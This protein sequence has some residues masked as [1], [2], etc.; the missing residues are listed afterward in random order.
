MT[1]H[2][3]DQNRVNPVQCKQ[4]GKMVVRV[5]II[6]VLTV[7]IL[8]DISKAAPK[9]KTDVDIKASEVDTIRAKPQEPEVILLIPKANQ[10]K[11]DK[12]KK[13]LAPK[14]QKETEKQ[15]FGKR[16]TYKTGSLFGSW[17]KGPHKSHSFSYH[18]IPVAQVLSD[19][20]KL[21]RLNIV[22]ADNVK[23]EVTFSA[24]NI[25]WIQALRAIVDATGLTAKCEGSIV[26]IEPK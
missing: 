3:V 15:P 13:K 19:I 9:N 20:S 5:V 11:A 24:K 21:S 7:F 4:R 16:S 22:L 12:K 1:G 18:K 10:K 17:P 14:I 8:V 26:F 23:G 6:A 2:L 25:T